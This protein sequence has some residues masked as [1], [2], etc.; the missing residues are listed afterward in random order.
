[1][2]IVNAMSDLQTGEATDVELAH[3]KDWI[4]SLQNYSEGNDL[5][6]LETQYYNPD[7]MREQGRRTASSRA[8]WAN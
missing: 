6:G 1:M 7:Y 5:T 8:A 3:M 2:V 4:Y